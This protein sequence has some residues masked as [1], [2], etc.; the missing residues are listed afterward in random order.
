MRLSGTSWP[1]CARGNRA[2]M[3]ASRPW[4]R[5][6]S[7][8]SVESSSAHPRNSAILG[9]PPSSYF[10]PRN[11]RMAPRKATK[12]RLNALKVSPP[13][14]LANFQKIPKTSYSAQ[15]GG[16]L[17]AEYDVSWLRRAQNEA[18]A[19][20]LRPQFSP[21]PARN[22]PRKRSKKRPEFRPQNP[23]TERIKRL[24]ARII[25]KSTPK[26]RDKD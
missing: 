24:A 10:W 20:F 13:G 21:A 17:C 2:D 16:A 1:L 19:P 7:S 14:I 9:R 11:S 18:F 4:W 26:N 3:R 22:R 6:P 23:K 8:S 25:S 15:G 12:C 5:E